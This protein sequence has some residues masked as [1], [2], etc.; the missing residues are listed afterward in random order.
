MR[1]SLQG[2][3]GGGAANDSN[4]KNGDFIDINNWTVI[5]SQ[6]KLNGL[7]TIGGWPT[8][9]DNKPTS[10]PV[11]DSANAACTYSYGLVS[12]DLPPG[13]AAPQQALRLQ[14]S[15]HSVAYATVHGPAVISDQVVELVSGQT[16]QFWWRGLAGGDAYDIYGYLLNV[17]DGNTVELINETG[18]NDTGV[19]SWALETKEIPVGGNYK[20]VFIAGTYDFTGGTAVGG[21]LLITGVG[22]TPPVIVNSGDVI[23][24]SAQLIGSSGLVAS[25]D[26]SWNAFMK[27][28]SVWS[29]NTSGGSSINVSTTVNF[30]ASRVYVFQ[31]GFDNSGTIY[32]DGVS[33]ATGTDTFNTTPT[34]NVTVTA[35][36]HDVRITGQN[37]AGASSPAGVAVLITAA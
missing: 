12:N 35:G 31:T 3:F 32:L 33:V 7:S 6:I 18:P 29:T 23:F 26:P 36:N 24:D 17:D 1:P 5:Q 14:N 27:A 22:T 2:F 15:G 11:G 30:P 9:Y 25:T 37:Q 20:F 21:L 13:F 4:F 28:H 8:P 16:V 19:T 10:H 34:N